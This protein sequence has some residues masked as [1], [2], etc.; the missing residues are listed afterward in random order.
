M[1]G[2]NA[3]ID[4]VFRNS[5]DRSSRLKKVM[6]QGYSVIAIEYKWKYVGID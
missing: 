4:D 3:G 6:K 5:E 1:H 2:V